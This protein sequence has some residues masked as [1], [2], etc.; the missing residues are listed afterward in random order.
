MKKLLA[1]I[2]FVF[3]SVTNSFAAFFIDGLGAYVNAGDL[4]NQTG[5]GLGVG[6]DINPNLNFLFRTVYTTA[7]KDKNT[8]SEAT[9][10]HVSALAGVEYDP[11]FQALGN[12]R[13]RWKT[14]ILVGM[15][16]SEVDVKAATE[17]VS[18]MGLACAFWTGLQYDLTQVISPF[19]DLGYHT[20]FYNDKLK[21]ASVRGYQIAAGIRFYINGSRDYT[22]D[23]Q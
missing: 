19:I 15:S 4:E 13:L 11:R 2:L 10:D 5:G 12:Y 20:S 3:L 17:T 18:D 9:Y 1:I 22:G 23:Y 21:D 14:S 7:T 8:V 16:N 6:F